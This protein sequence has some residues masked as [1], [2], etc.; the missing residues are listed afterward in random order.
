MRY[1]TYVQSRV[2]TVYTY[3]MITVYTYLTDSSK[4]S[5]YE[6]C[7]SLAELSKYSVYVC[8]KYSVYVFD[9][10]SQATHVHESRHIIM[11]RTHTHTDCGRQ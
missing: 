9:S 4:Y 11:A 8:D 1:V 10:V 2:N 6:S 7:H 3:V 5:V